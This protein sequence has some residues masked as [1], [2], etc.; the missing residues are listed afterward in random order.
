MRPFYVRTTFSMTS[1]AADARGDD[2]QF[3]GFDVT[4]GESA[5][6]TAAHAGPYRRP[7]A[8]E[9]SFVREWQNRRSGETMLP[10]IVEVEDLPAV[11]YRSARR[12]CTWLNGGPLR[13]TKSASC[14][15][16]ASR[17]DRPD[18]LTSAGRDR[19]QGYILGQPAANGRGRQRSRKRLRSRGR[20]LIR[21][22]MPVAEW[23][24]PRSVNSHRLGL[25]LGCRVVIETGTFAHD[26]AEQFR[27]GSRCCTSS[28]PNL[29]QSQ[30]G[31]VVRT[32]RME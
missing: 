18:A 10:R 1:P 29:L 14:R 25:C 31:D 13:T 17:C 3:G 7:P 11:A 19:P 2:R 23:L 8:A 16:P 4:A 15:W 24:R 20:R 12:G 28:K 6:S 22:L 9:A 21:T 32:V 26:P 30:H 5:A 27:V